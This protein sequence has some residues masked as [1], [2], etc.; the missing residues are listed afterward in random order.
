MKKTEKVERIV[1]NEEVSEANCDRCGKMIWSKDNPCG[2]MIESQESHSISFIGGYGSV[3]GD[4]VK[5]SCD[6]C[7]QCFYDLIS[8]FCYMSREEDSADS[9][10]SCYENDEH[11]QWPEPQPLARKGE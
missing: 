5:V 9:A 8:D 1:I 10:D 7:Q 2:Y 4:G 6:L 11:W 3:F